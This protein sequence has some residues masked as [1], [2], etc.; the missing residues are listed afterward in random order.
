[1]AHPLVDLE[2]GLEVLIKQPSETRIYDLKFD[3][4]LPSGA[5]IS[6]INQV[7]A[8]PRGNVVNSDTLN[9]GSPTGVG[10]TSVQMTISGGKDGEDYKITAVIVDSSGNTLEGEGMLYVRDL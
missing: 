10:T 2:T 3:D 4:V 1:M 8:E 7:K 5:T 6:Q 9:V